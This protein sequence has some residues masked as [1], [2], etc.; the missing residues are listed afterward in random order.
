M[1][2]CPNCGFTCLTQYEIRREVIGRRNEQMIQ[3]RVEGT[4]VAELA[5]IYG[6]HYAWVYN[7]TSRS[8]AIFPKFKTGVK[9]GT[10][11]NLERDAEVVRLRAAGAT[12]LAVA[13]QFNLSRQRVWQ[14]ITNNNRKKRIEP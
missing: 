9:Q 6:L 5:K 1:I 13:L 11:H 3:R 12:T 4:P 2:T 14:I 7:I 10:K 8:K